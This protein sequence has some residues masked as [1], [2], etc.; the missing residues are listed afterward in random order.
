MKKLPLICLVAFAVIATLAYPSASYFYS[1]EIDK[2][3]FFYN[4][5]KLAC[6]ILV[7]GYIPQYI[8]S[9]MIVFPLAVSAIAFRWLLKSF[10]E[11]ALHYSVNEWWFLCAVVVWMAYSWVT[12]NWQRKKHQLIYFSVLIFL[13]ALD[14]I[15]LI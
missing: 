14:A 12:W 6:L 15:G 10:I 4:M 5:I 3:S 11:G 8:G 2:A 9:K 7:V 1:A 13:V